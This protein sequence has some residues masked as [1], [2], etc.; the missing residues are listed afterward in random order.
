MPSVTGRLSTREATTKTRDKKNAAPLSR[1]RI[2]I[3]QNH[4]AKTFLD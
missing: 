3:L 1:G 2:P 4:K